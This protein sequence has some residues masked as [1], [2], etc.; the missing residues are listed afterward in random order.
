MPV[1]SPIN[2]KKT[3]T[4]V[5]DLCEQMDALIAQAESQV[6][7]YSSIK[8]ELEVEPGLLKQA[9]SLNLGSE[10][11]MKQAV[12]EF[13]SWKTE[14]KHDVK[15][16]IAEKKTELKKARKERRL[17]QREALGE[18]VVTTPRT[19]KKKTRGRFI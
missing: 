18:P 14:V 1:S 12:A 9:L 10:D 17:K 8:E 15:A 11:D 5:E 4:R 7:A 6:M 19:R 3:K 2:T 13:N 16:A